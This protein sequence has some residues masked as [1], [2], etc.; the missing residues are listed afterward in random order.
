MMGVNNNLRHRSGFTIVELLIVNVVIAVLAAISVVAYTGIQ[1]RANDTSVKSDLSNLAR[2]I[3]AYRAIDG[4]YPDISSLSIA[5][6][7]MKV[8]RNA[9]GDGLIHTDGFSYNLIYCVTSNGAKY[10]LV[11]WSM[12]GKGYAIIDGSLGDFTYDPAP[13][14]TTCPRLGAS[15]G[16]QA[17]MK[18][19]GVWNSYI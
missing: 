11:A 7:G 14:A 13:G 3:E 16:G 4:M 15:G 8:N 1:N 6:S 17:W 10:G 18:H 9:Y 5:F 12:S 2:K 19:I